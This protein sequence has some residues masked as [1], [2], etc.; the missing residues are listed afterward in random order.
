MKLKKVIENKVKVDYL[1][2]QGNLDLDLKY[3]KKQIE[4]GI[5]QNNNNNFSTNVQGY[6]TSYGYFTNNKNFLKSIF[7]LFDYLDSLKNIK[8]YYLYNC[9][10][11]K[12]NF[13]HFTESHDHDPCYLSGIIYL[14]NH[15]QTLLFPQLNKEI[16]PKSNSFILFSSFLVH[17]TNRN[18]TDED[19]YALS[20]NL[21]KKENKNVY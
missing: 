10:G 9:W 5:K 18:V 2:I 8:P 13:S 21:K 14:N 12:E 15:S 20:F 1:F 11:L 3:F 7:P 19:K 4:D 6:M 16:K 17:Q